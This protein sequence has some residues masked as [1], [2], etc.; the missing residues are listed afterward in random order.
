MSEK[1]KTFSHYF[2]RY[3]WIPMGIAYMIMGN[4]ALTR[5]WYDDIWVLYGNIVFIVGLFMCFGCIILHIIIFFYGEL[6]RHIR[7]TVRDELKRD[8]TQ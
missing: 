5:M 7:K 8:D 6:D 1:L 3:G 4:D 2:L